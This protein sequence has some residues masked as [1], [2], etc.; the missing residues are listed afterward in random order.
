MESLDRDTKLFFQLI[1]NQRP[2]STAD[3]QILRVEQNEFTTPAE[4]NDF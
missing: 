2:S 3:T 4:I 1:K